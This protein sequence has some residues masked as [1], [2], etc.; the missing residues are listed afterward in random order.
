MFRIATGRADGLACF[1]S[2]AQ[3]FL[4][5]LAPLLAFPLVGTV[6]GLF[7][8]GPRRALT[9]LAMTLCA[10]LTPAVLSFQIARWWKREDAWFRFATAFNWCEW[11]LPLVAVLAML[12]LGLAV[13]AGVKENVVGAA[14]IVMLGL[15][16]LWLH[17]FLA[18]NG[19]GLSAPKALLLVVL[20]NAGTAAAVLAP[21][22]LGPGRG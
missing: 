6:M 2:S 20:V 13:S 14:F 1:G 16:G 18:R 15:Y 19:L 22:L 5:S 21:G 17:W 12:P 9:D 11:I 10:I 7:T 4:A 3:S 8:E